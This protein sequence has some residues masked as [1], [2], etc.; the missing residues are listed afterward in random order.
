[1]A[2]TQIALVRL[3]IFDDS[4]GT[5]NPANYSTGA[6]VSGGDP[7]FT[8]AEIQ[9]FLDHFATHM[10]D[11]RA[12]AY[13]ASS[14]L[15]KVRSVKDI[16]RSVQGS[17]G[18]T[19]TGDARKLTQNWLTLAKEYKATAES[20]L[21]EEGNPYFDSIEYA[22]TEAQATDILVKRYQREDLI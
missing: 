12:I 3:N 9:D 14:Q 15:C 21:N 11:T 2:L 16:Y 18:G 17:V 20:I 10:S 8:D 22:D 4:D 19:V 7:V 6:F 1:M 5:G 13:M